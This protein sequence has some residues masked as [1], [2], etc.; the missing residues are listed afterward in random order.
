MM[1]LVLALIVLSPT[2]DLLVN[3]SWHD[4]QRLLQIA[5]IGLVLIALLIEMMKGGGWPVL[6]VISRVGITVLAVGVAG[7]LW[8]AVSLHWAYTE[9]A[10]LLGLSGLFLYARLFFF[11]HP[12][13]LLLLPYVSLIIAAILSV[14]FLA[15]LT[16]AFFSGLPLHAIALLDGFNNVRWF[17]QFQALSLPLI[18][19]LAV[20]LRRTVTVSAVFVL[21][22]VWWLGIFVGE[23]RGAWLAVVFVMLVMALPHLGNRALLRVMLVSGGVGLVCYLVLF[24]LIAPKLGMH[25]S[26]REVSTLLGTSSGRSRLWLHSLLQIAERPWFGW[27]GMAF[28]GER[29]I[30]EGHP[31]NLFMQIAYEW[32]LLALFGV[33][34]LLGRAF[35]SLFSALQGGVQEAHERAVIYALLAMLSHS[36]VSGVIAM[37]YSQTWLAILGGAVWAVCDR[38]HVSPVPSNR[39]RGWNGGLLLLLGC[40]TFW[41]ADVAIRDYSRL[42]SFEFR[43]GYGADGPRFWLQG[44]I[45]WDDAEPSVS[46]KISSS[47]E[48]SEDGE[49]GADILLE[50]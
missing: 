15:A 2:V 45:S 6:P 34:I 21:L 33:L 43:P 13:C 22:I 30:S 5:I 32:G 18:A 27:G 40:A 41:L 42:V 44:G 26:G 28:A 23:S 20:S 39:G 17:G 9:L 14:K 36:M 11:R 10:L 7:S 38:A 24:Q 12:S 47:V 46:K 8:G 16:N 49:A 19:S 37:P 3:V 4:Q 25:D 29:L 48:S 35:L 1:W 50:Q 31:H